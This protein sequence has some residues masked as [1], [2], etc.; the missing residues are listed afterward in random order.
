[1]RP[2]F[3]PHGSAMLVVLPT[4]TE[5]P[6]CNRN[7]RLCVNREG[8]TLCVSCDETVRTSGQEVRP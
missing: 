3:F 1:M 6:K 7:V 4:S 2:V 8:R 5:C